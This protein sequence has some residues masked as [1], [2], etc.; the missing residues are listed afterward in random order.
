M[1]QDAGGQK[2]DKDLASHPSPQNFQNHASSS[3]TRSYDI[4][5]DTC[6]VGDRGGREWR[7]NLEPNHLWEETCVAQQ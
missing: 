3:D 6:K 1:Q 2:H 5:R 4:D 7:D